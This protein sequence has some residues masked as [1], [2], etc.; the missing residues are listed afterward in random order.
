MINVTII[1]MKTTLMSNFSVLI[2]ICDSLYN[3]KCGFPQSTLALSRSIP[4]LD[5]CTFLF[6]TAPSLSDSAT[7]GT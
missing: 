1:S 7:N 4:S 2:C 3:T 5:L 6:F